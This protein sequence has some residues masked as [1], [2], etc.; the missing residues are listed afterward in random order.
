MCKDRGHLKLAEEVDHIVP[1]KGDPVLFWDTRNWQ[2]LCKHDH[3]TIKARIERS[4]AS[5]GCEAD[6][7]PSD[8][9]HHWNSG[10]GGV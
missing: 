9:D 3:Q 5:R 6:G 4:D 1:H 10:E 2:G 8:P 7:T